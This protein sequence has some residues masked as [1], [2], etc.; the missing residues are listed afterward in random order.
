MRIAQFFALVLTALALVPVGTHLA[1]MANKIGMNEPSYF[2]AQSIYNGWAWSGV[3]L[4][5]SILANAIAALASRAQFWP[6][7]LAALASLLMLGTLAIVFAFTFPANQ[8]TADWTTVPDDWPFLRR[9][10]EMSHAV[11]AIVTFIAFCC[12]SISAMS[13]QR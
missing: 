13:S 8:A 6:F 5:G 10:W 7:V 11:N 2:I 4:M 9:Q 1:A 12:I 3:I